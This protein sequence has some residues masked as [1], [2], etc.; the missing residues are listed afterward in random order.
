[1]IKVY[2]TETKTITESALK[3]A[4]DILPQWR[5]EYVCKQKSLSNRINGAFAYLLLQKLT[6]DVFG[7]ATAAPFTYGEH[8]KPFFSDSDIKFSISHCQNAVAAVV[9]EHEVGIDVADKRTI[10]EKI[11]SRICSDGELKRFNA[12]QDKQLFLRR[13]WCEKESLAKLDGSGFTKGFK[14]YDTTQRPADLFSDR[15]GCLLA[16]SGKNAETAEI[17]DIFWEALIQK[18]LP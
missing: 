13:L 5:R 9:S 11:A 7:I 18:Q 14:V 6:A 12:A 3:T 4:L 16:V 17:A 1:M 10:N 2:T 15:G 8:G